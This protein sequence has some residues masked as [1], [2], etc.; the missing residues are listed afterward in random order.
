MSKPAT[1]LLIAILAVSSLVMVETAFAQSAPPPSTPTFTLKYLGR[2]MDGFANNSHIRV[3]IDNQLLP[4]NL[5]NGKY[6][7]YY[8]IR[9]K[10]HSS[11]HFYGPFGDLMTIDNSLSPDPSEASITEELQ[12]AIPAQSN[13]SKTTYTLVISENFNPDADDLIDVQ[14]KAIIGHNFTRWYHTYAI[15]HYWAGIPRY[16]YDEKVL[17]SVPSITQDSESNWSDTQ[18]VSIEEIQTPSPEPAISQEPAFILAIV[19][20]VAVFVFG[21]VLLYRIKKK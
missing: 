7:I 18:T 5:D 4:A 13:S 12:N 11:Q 16:N 3:T 6:S 1:L 15:D 17:V 2:Y 20:F 21:L 10:P 19:A 14:I 8:S 9:F